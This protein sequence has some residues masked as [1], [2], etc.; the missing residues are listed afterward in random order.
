MDLRKP[1]KLLKI[2]REMKESRL[3]G[4]EMLSWSSWLIRQTICTIREKRSTIS[5]CRD[6]KVSISP[7]LVKKSKNV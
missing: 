2:G 1:K 3:I 7:K 6:W 4:R 5:T